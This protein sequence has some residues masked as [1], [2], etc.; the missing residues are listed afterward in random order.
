VEQEIAESE[1]TALDL[2]LETD[3]ERSELLEK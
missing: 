3:V 2:V 1:K